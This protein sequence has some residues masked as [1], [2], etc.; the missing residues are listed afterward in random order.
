MD[1]F[2]PGKMYANQVPPYGGVCGVQGGVLAPGFT[3]VPPAGPGVV[4]PP[5]P[6]VVPP[7]VPLPGNPGGPAPP[8]AFPAMSAAR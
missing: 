2:R 4:L 1:F 8:P 7:P 6:G 5:G 3:A